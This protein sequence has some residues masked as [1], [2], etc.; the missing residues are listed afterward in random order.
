MTEFRP[1]TGRMIYHIL[2][3]R[4]AVLVIS[5]DSQ[6]KPSGMVASWT[7]S[8]SHSPPLVGVAIVPTRYTYGLIRASKEFTL[9]VFTA[10]FVKEIQYLGTASGK[11]EDKFS[12]VRLALEPSR[13]VRPPR[14]REAIGVMECRLER[15]I[16]AGGD[17]DL[18]VGRVVEA[19][20][21]EEFFEEVYQPSKA[22]VLLHIGS[23][24]YTTPSNEIIVPPKI[25]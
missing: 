15:I 2:H 1:V 6:G 3:P 17:H 11:Y 14:V 12:K 21:K 18:F 13:S 19:Y 8:L 9:N 16:D 20:A 7:I 10:E 4:P 23:R 5:I 25:E 24:L 22:K